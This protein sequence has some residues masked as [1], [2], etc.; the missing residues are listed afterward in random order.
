MSELIERLIGMG[1]VGV[2]CLV[3]FVIFKLADRH[4]KRHVSHHK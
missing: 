1:S 4:S 2:A 3:L